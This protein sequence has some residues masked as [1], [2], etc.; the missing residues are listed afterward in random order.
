MG[1]GKIFK[2]TEKQT[3]M[4]TSIIIKG[5]QTLM[6]PASQDHCPLMTET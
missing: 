1:D 3:K 2:S 5:H 4:N 6:Y